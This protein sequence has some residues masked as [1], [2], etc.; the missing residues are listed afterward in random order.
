MGCCKCEEYRWPDPQDVVWKDEEGDGKEYCVFHAPVEH[1]GKTLQD[2]QKLVHDRIDA[3]KA[4]ESDQGTCDFRGTS[5]PDGVSFACYKSNN[6]LPAIV[7]SWATFGEGAHFHGT[8]FRGQAD[9]G[10]A[11]F[12]AGAHFGDATFG[13]KADFRDA[14]FGERAYFCGATLGPLAYFKGATFGDGAHF[15]GT[16]VGEG[17]HFGG[18]TFGVGAFFGGATVAESAY[19]EGATFG[20]HAY[21]EGVTFG[22]RAHFGKATFGEGAHL[23]RATFGK[24]AF[25]GGTRF[26]KGAHFAGATFGPQADFEGATFGDGAH[27]A[28]ATFGNWT[29][30]DH[31]V[32]GKGSSFAGTAFSGPIFFNCAKFRDKTNFI[33]SMFEGG[34]YF[35]H[36]T[37]ADNVLLSEVQF[38]GQSSF[39]GA[40]FGKQV[41]FSKCS[42]PKPALFRN[43]LAIEDLRYQD[44]TVEQFQNADFLNCPLKNITFTNVEWPRHPTEERYCIPMESKPSKLPAVADFYRQMKKRCRDEQNDAEASLWHY[45]EK[46]AQ[47]Q[48]H[49]LEKPN[50]FQRWMLETYRIISRYGEDPWQA[51]KV[52]LLLLF[53]LL[54][55]LAFG[56]AAKIGG[57]PFPLSIDGF[58]KLGLAF[59]QYALFIKPDWSPPAFYDIAALLLSRLL[60]PIQAA[61]FAFALRNKLHR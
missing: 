36:A 16:T 1:K 26:G 18:A 25:F 42:F 23:G 45:A 33:K 55:A 40:D 28:G 61:I 27:F 29:R 50:S 54:C 3:L 21:F 13:E 12:G 7:F 17:A 4:Q 34:A 35:F 46:E 53:A 57:P 44:M 37:F 8:T 39:Y 49:R 51:A 30:F 48:H 9:F 22:E 52:L 10:N 19:F 15:G 58:G 20:A 59:A 6:P 43:L 24:G 14:T 31:V 32:I 41:I 60:I 2:F 56:A 5:F 47:L 38:K 11:T